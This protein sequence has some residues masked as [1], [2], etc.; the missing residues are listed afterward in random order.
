MLDGDNRHHANHCLNRI[1]SASLPLTLIRPAMSAFMASSLPTTSTMKS[2]DF[3][4]MVAVGLGTGSRT[5]HHIVYEEMVSERNR[6]A[7]RYTWRGKHSGRSRAADIGPRHG[8]APLL[9]K[10]RGRIKVSWISE[11]GKHGKA[12]LQVPGFPHQIGLTVG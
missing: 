10:L 7:Y 1:R 3:I 6:I 2:S 8:N 11:I 9:L 12:A 5:V 4:R